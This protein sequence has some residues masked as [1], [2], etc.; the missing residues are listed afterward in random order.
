MVEKRVSGVFRRNKNVI[1]LIA[2][3]ALLILIVI[4]MTNRMIMEMERSALS[5]VLRQLSDEPGFH[6]D[7]LSIHK[8][9]F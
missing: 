2:V 6:S 9:H 5:S 4:I 3:V 7:F 1:I 8:K